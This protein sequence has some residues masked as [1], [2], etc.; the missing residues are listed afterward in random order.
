MTHAK[1]RQYF[2]ARTSE[3]AKERGNTEWVGSDSGISK[4]YSDDIIPILFSEII[5]RQYFKLSEYK[6][7]GL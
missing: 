6:V 7:Q 5:R 1:F 4:K 3:F 2:S